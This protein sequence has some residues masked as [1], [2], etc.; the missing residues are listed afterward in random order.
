MK[1]KILISS[2]FARRAKSLLMSPANI[3]S[4]RRASMILFLT[5]PL[6]TRQTLGHM[7][8]QCSKVA[9]TMWCSKKDD[10]SSSIVDTLVVIATYVCVNDCL[11]DHNAAETLRHP[12]NRS[13][14]VLLSPKAHVLRRFSPAPLIPVV[15]APKTALELYPYKSTLVRGFRSGRKSLSQRLPLAALHVWVACNGLSKG[16]RPWKAMTSTTAALF[17]VS[18]G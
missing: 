4:L 12:D 9:S 14:L 13:C 8:T 11:L 2:A 5:L 15:E 16:S 10:A 3:E 18:I 7:I 6:T 1:F 17:F